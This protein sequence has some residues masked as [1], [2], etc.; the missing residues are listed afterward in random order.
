MLDVLVWRC[1]VSHVSAL[2]PEPLALWFAGSLDGYVEQGGGHWATG[3]TKQV[4]TL[5]ISACA[6][7]CTGLPGCA[8]FFRTKAS[9]DC[10]TYTET[11][12][13]SEWT[14]AAG[15]DA[16]LR[17]TPHAV[18]PHMRQV[19]QAQVMCARRVR[20]ATNI[21]APS[22]GSDFERRPL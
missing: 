8:A 1:S 11:P 18:A 14:P 4:S 15:H 17:G 22:L 9:G 13:G 2:R 12:A 6:S 19:R 20:V 3:H 21:D 7:V 10:Y 5:T 16:F